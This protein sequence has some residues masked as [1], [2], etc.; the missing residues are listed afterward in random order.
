MRKQ[1]LIDEKGQAR[2]AW[3]IAGGKRAWGKRPI[4]NAH[5]HRYLETSVLAKQDRFPMQTRA[6]RQLLVVSVVIVISLRLCH[7]PERLSICPKEEYGIADKHDQ[8][9]NSL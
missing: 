8:Q 6:Q 7:T 9:E 5:L 4:W 2:K 3:Q 1:Y